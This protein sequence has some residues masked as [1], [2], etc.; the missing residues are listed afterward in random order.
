MQAALRPVFDILRW[1]AADSRRCPLFQNP[2]ILG[3][4][5]WTRKCIA[6]GSVV[7]IPSALPV[8]STLP[9]VPPPPPAATTASGS[10]LASFAD[11][12]KL[13]AN[14]EPPPNSTPVAKLSMG[15][16]DKSGKDQKKEDDP[17]KKLTLSPDLAAVPV[18]PTTTPDIKPLHLG[19]SN[20][21]GSVPEKDKHPAV[22]D[23]KPDNTPKDGL[24]QARTNAPVAFGVNLSNANPTKGDT[25]K[26]SQTS[27]TTKSAAPEG[28]KSSAEA[29][30]PAESKSASSRDQRQHSDSS[31]DN[32]PSPAVTSHAGKAAEP[33][34]AVHPSSPGSADQTPSTAAT[35]PNAY[36]PASSI[37]TNKAASTTPVSSVSEPVQSHLPA[38]TQ[39]IDLKIGG[40]DNSQVDVRISQ[41]A[42]D[43]QVT[44]RTPDGDLA[45]SLR[46]H[47][48][49]LSD[50]LSQGGV[51]GDVWQ[52]QTA[53]AANTGTNDSGSRYSDDAQTQQQAQQQHSRGNPQQGSQ[54][55]QQDQARQQATWSSELNQAEKEIN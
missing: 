36:T 3:L 49:E 16:N 41:R 44:V 28:G 50:R 37:T 6:A 33:G 23:L 27:P 24:A 13:L 45:Q 51:A 55:Q 20:S 10:K 39:N 17:K 11:L 9:K 5:D 42:G 2:A 15:G 21:E 25:P 18:P 54:Q 32:Q 26:G 34:F 48:P 12:L 30:K 4:F 29:V 35:A 22:Q 46:Q 53:Q 19:W 52:P 31:Q 1:T 38:R 47:L 14:P 7:S 40:P 43:V 8:T